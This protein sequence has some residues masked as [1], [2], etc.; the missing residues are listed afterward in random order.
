MPWEITVT[1]QITDVGTRVVH[2]GA[3]RIATAVPVT[4]VL[5]VP[6]VSVSAPEFSEDSSVI[7]AAAAVTVPALLTALT[8]KDPVAVE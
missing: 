5:V 2:A 6:A 7:E 1:V 3:T 4:L 8:E